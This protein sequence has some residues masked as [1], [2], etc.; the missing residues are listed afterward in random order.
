[1]INNRLTSEAKELAK[2]V[3]RACTDDPSLCQNADI[4]E[5]TSMDEVRVA[6]RSG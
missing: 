5:A 6:T 1:M 4:T 3:Q 2:A